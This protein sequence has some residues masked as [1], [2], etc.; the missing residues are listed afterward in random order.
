MPQSKAAQSRELVSV[1]PW[2][3]WL[4]MVGISNST[5]RRLVREGKVT[6]TWLSERRKGIRSDH[7]QAFLDSCQS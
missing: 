2:S 7:H 5:G 3:T 4:R 1:I 6:V